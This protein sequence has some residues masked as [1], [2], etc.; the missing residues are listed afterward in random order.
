MSW[1]SLELEHPRSPDQLAD[2]PPPVAQSWARSIAAGATPEGPAEE[3]LVEASRLS[4]H[5]DRVDGLLRTLDEALVPAVQGLS[6]RHFS[7][8]FADTEGVIVARRGGGAFEEVAQELWL[9]PGSVWREDTRGTNAIGTALAEK[10]PVAVYGAAHLARANHGLVCYAAP[11][12]DPW[13]DV[14]GVLDATSH[15]G[16][17]DPMVGVAVFAAARALEEAVQ[18]RLLV[19]GASL[20][21]RLL[22]RLRDPALLVTP[23]GCVTHANL[24]AFGAG[25]GLGTPVRRQGDVARVRVPVSDI[26]PISVDELDAA[27]RGQIRIPGMDVEPVPAPNGRSAAYLVVLTPAARAVTAP[28]LESDA[29]GELVGTDS[30]LVVVRSHA[31]QVARSSLPVLITGETGTGKE[32]V[33]RG[34]HRAS[35]RAGKPFVDVNCGA[36]APSL[37][38]AELFGHAA[39][40]FTDAGAVGRDGLLARA[41][42][43]TLFLD[44][45]GEMPLPLQALF[46]RFLETGTYHRVG[47]PQPRSASVR[48]VAATRRDLDA[49]V[50]EG[51]FRADLLYRVRGAL[52]RLPPVRERADRALLARTL[53]VQLSGELRLQRVPFL[54]EGALDRVDEHLWPGNVRELKMALHHALVVSEGARTI[55][56]W[57][58]PVAE[59]MPTPSPRAAGQGLAGAQA[60]ALRRALEAHDGNVTAAAKALG[61]ARSTVYRMVKRLGL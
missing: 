45:L 58:L 31:G 13:G 49:M 54:S 32:L 43:G 21:E 11:V 60:T 4:L 23:R 16:Q 51:T 59:P 46:L 20:V 29:F 26:L 17:A 18:L 3:A 61:V 15:R 37:I 19:G 42:G 34:I 41:D 24:E 53:L 40:A 33:A 5:L 52:L 14:M 47:D 1:L 27:A 48:L 35:E 56:P 38:H 28:A 50:A 6:D 30:A 22:G 12:K 7:L 55:E 25:L 8:L 44:E 57:H 9:Q 39:H 36:I 10:R 2:L